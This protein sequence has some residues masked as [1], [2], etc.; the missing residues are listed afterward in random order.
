M[1]VGVRVGMGMGVGWRVRVEVRGRGRIGEEEAVR[2]AFGP[3][4]GG[5]FGGEEEE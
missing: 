1:G 3:R 2:G 5:F 4:Y